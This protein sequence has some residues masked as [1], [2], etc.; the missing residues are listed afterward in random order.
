ME[1]SASVWPRHRNLFPCGLFALIPRVSPAAHVVRHHGLP[2]LLI[3]LVSFAA[4]VPLIL[5]GPSCGHDFD[6]HF[7]SWLEAS[8]DWHTGLVYPHWLVLANYGAGEPRF[9][10]YPPLSWFIGAALGSAASL[11]AS[12]HTAWTAAP[13]LFTGISFF[14]AGSAVYAFLRTF[15]S[16][17]AATLCACLFIAN[18]YLLFVAYER[19]A[20]AEL[21]ATALIAL[22]LLLAMRPAFAVM[23][24]AIVIGALWLT[25]APSAVMGCYLLAGITFLRIVLERRWHLAWQAAVGCALGTALAGFY[26]VPA[27]YEQRWVQIKQA[28]G[29]GM[30][31]EDS[32]FFE[33]TGQLYHDQVL[34]TASLI[35]LILVVTGFVA[36]LAAWRRQDTS[37]TRLLALLTLPLIALFFLQFRI[38]DV[39]W[40][41]A[42]RLQFL[43]FPW[44]WLQV[45]SILS[46]ALLALAIDHLS[47]RLLLR[48]AASLVIAGSIWACAHTFYAACDVD[49]AVAGQLAMFHD[50]SGVQGT[51][52]YTA[53]DADNSQVLQDIPPVRVLT[54]PNAELPAEN[55]G[56]NPEWI[57]DWAFPTTAKATSTIRDWSPQ[58]RRIELDARQP[59]YAVLTL[60]DYPAWHV[61]M[62]GRPQSIDIHR[63]DGLMVLAVPA[64][65]STIDVL[66]QNTP[67][68]LWGRLLSAVAALLLLPVWLWQRRQYYPLA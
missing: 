31:I 38:S 41:A 32:F 40:H 47:S 43:Q 36:A 58:H 9:I 51:D 24:A 3:F 57:S 66:W 16:G 49:D 53:A 63:E 30:R 20:F 54:D 19:T 28:I 50:G 61:S 29:E 25:N 60:M 1:G 67:D 14:A 10:F 5:R 37:R 65:K 18:P 8:R 62:N 26:L 22:L 39:I 48:L 7:L 17:S 44:R 15:A 55:A 35:T 21:L 64:G 56:D 68:I 42:P 34:H 12:P 33:H 52:E 11:V 6:F 23:P 27:A 4:V 46:V 13:I 2:L 59:A 45:I